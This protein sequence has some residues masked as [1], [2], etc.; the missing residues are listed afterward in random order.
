MIETEESNVFIGDLSGMFEKCDPTA[1][2]KIMEG[3]QNYGVM[4]TL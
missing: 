1:F 4:L 2:H 3:L